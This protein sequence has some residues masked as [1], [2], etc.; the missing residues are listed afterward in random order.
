M[1]L[2]HDEAGRIVAIG[3][4]YLD[5]LYSYA[6][7][8][9]GNPAEAE[10]L[11]EEAYV[12]ALG[13]MGQPRLCGNLKGWLFTILR[14]SWFNQL[15]ESRNDPQMV[16]AETPDRTANCAVKPSTGSHDLYVSTVEA[17]Q[18]RRAI[19]ELPADLREII[20]LREYEDFSYQEIACV[21][22]D[23]VGIVMSRLARARAKLREMLFT[24]AARAI[25][26][27]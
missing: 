6:L 18:V 27:E 10:G 7:V 11:V 5:G 23:S 19:H 17:E 20:F 21:L 16:E 3:I 2:R 26:L 9:T 12:H 4:E 8:L 22:E 25:H 1:S 13:A 24:V 15:R 14:S